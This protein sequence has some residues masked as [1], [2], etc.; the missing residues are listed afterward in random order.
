MPRMDAR[1]MSLLSD[2]LMLAGRML[3]T[4]GA[5]TSRVQE[6]VHRMALNCGFASAEV[7]C[8]P[9]G[10]FTTLIAGHLSVT[11]VVNVDERGIDLGKV[12]FV[13]DLSRGLEEGRVTPR[14]VLQALQKADSAQDADPF[15][16]M[17]AA[18]G[19]GSACWTLLLGG[20]LAD[21]VPAIVI[22]FLVQGAREQSGRFA[23]NPLAI[24]FAAALGTAFA[25]ILRILGFGE[26]LGPLVVGAI[27]PLAPGLAVT[28]AVR[29]LVGGH[30][31]AGVARS[32]EALL[33][34]AAIAG[35]VST[36]LS[37]THHWIR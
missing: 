36:S 9:T 27:L 2:M 8:M 14:E 6:T 32:A 1:H 35:G 22:G 28:T 23:P 25:V 30:L 24:F 21:V 19:L 5:S 26:H 33:I 13:N 16:W 7:F 29:D 10:I 11:R 31:V 17:F 18:R 34:A 12:A 4:S 37:M 15:I 20:G 3:L